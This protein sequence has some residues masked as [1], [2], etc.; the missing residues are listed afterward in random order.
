MRDTLRT[1]CV[2]CGSSAG[3]RTAY[4]DAA[5]RVGQLTAERGLTVVYG[6]GKVGL[7]GVLADACLGAGGRVIGVMPQMLV[8]KEI[9]HRGITELRVV[10]SMH[11]RKALMADLAD[12]FLALPGGFG[13]F[14]EFFE[15]LTWT[16][17]GLQRKACGLLNVDGYYDPLLRLADQALAEGFLRAPHREMLLCDTDAARM[18]DRLSE[19]QPP[20]VEKVLD[21]TTR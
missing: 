4:A 2:F 16:Q 1:V 5:R 17:L 15:I 12:A 9:A 18:L 21:R 11:E 3:R 14:E 19:Y 10:R 13:T 20:A 7:M 8:D 6:G